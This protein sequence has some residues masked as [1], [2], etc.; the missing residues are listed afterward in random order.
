MSKELMFLIVVLVSVNILVL[1]LAF[2]NAKV[3]DWTVKERTW[4]G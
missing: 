1:T 3:K 4:R 2:M